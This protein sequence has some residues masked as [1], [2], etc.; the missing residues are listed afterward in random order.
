MKD[1]DILNLTEK[2]IEKIERVK[3][4]EERLKNAE[5][6]RLNAE[7]N[8]ESKRAWRLVFERAPAESIPFIIYVVY[9]AATALYFLFKLLDYTGASLYIGGFLLFVVLVAPL[10]VLPSK[11]WEKVGRYLKRKILGHEE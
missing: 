10:L 8:L 3:G 6:E 4:A 2:E 9:V 11:S 7:A 5:T 1:E